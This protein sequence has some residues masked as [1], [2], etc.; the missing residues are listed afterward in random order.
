MRAI[1]AVLALMATAA[2]AEYPT[3][4]ASSYHASEYPFDVYPAQA[5]FL[6]CTTSSPTYAKMGIPGW[7]YWLTLEVYPWD[8]LEGAETVHGSQPSIEF[9]RD[10]R[11]TACNPAIFSPA[12]AGGF[13]HLQYDYALPNLRIRLV[14]PPA[15][16][17]YGAAYNGELLTVPASAFF[18][19][20][21]Q[22]SAECVWYEQKV[23]QASYCT[24]WQAVV[25]GVGADVYLRGDDLNVLKVSETYEPVTYFPVVAPPAPE[26][27]PRP[28]RKKRE[29]KCVWNAEDGKYDCED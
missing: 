27:S 25:P 5:D 6:P 13:L 23:E 8:L 24:V 29:Q 26:P 18:Q 7:T 20:Y 12:D 17:R 19:E 21:G 14:G 4:P 10:V 9:A 1:I 3:L 22:T 11:G 28:H 16:I 2:F 15:N